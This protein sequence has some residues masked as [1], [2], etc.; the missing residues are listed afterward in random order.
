M[1]TSINTATPSETLLPTMTAN[2]HQSAF[3]PVLRSPNFSEPIDIQQLRNKSLTVEKNIESSDDEV[4][5]ETTEDDDNPVVPLDSG[6]KN[7]HSN[8][9]MSSHSGHST[10]PL[11]WS[12]PQE[13]VS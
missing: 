7:P 4:D 5:I 6:L 3:R 12:P 10:S 8:S 11:C 1:P 9:T 13:T 2:I